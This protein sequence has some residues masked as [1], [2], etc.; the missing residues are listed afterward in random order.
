M[1]KLFVVFAVLILAGC[2]RPHGPAEKILDPELV[3][4][5]TGVAQTKVT[6][7]RNKQFIGGGSGGLCK[8]LVSIDDKEVA[9]LRQNQFVTAYLNNGP[10]KL[11]VSND[12]NVMSMGMRKTLDI[13]GDGQDQEYIAE[14]G[15]WG[16]YR[17]WRE[18]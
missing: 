18:K 3:T 13:I 11:K 5:K 1:K 4:P 2:A 8:F 14:Q 10:H 17:M 16:Q 6:V 15:I 9:L 7:T 12:C